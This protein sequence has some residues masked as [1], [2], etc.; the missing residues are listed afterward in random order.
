MRKEL[1]LSNKIA[2]LRILTKGDSIE[3]MRSYYLSPWHFQPGRYII[4][5][6]EKIGCVIEAT[7]QAPPR[8]IE[9]RIPYE[10]LTH[11][12]IKVAQKLLQ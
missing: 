8:K 9:V 3:L 4:I 10:Y 11:E 7:L 5:R 6:H 2:I 1:T 12:S